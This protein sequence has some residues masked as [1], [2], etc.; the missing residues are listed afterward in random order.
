MGAPTLEA[1]EVNVP[2]AYTSVCSFVS[3]LLIE[4]FSFPDPEQLVQIRAVRVAGQ[5]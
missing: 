1:A 3:A 2:P 5:A 4:P